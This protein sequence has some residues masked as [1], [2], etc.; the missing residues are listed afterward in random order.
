MTAALIAASRREQLAVCCWQ[1]P[2]GG[3]GSSLLGGPFISLI[4]FFTIEAATWSLVS[5]LNKQH[6]VQISAQIAEFRDGCVSGGHW[7]DICGGAQ[8]GSA[9]GGGAARDDRRPANCA[10]AEPARF[11]SAER[12]RGCDQTH[13]SRSLD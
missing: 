9:R 5:E 3:R 1:E 11:R 10:C 12:G 4:Q 7:R 8:K 13:R 2:R 6:A